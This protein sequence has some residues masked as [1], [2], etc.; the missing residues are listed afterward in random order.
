M[1]KE[2]IE[3]LSVKWIDG[4]LS[5]SEEKQLHALME[6]DPEM[7]ADLH[8]MKAVAQSL[9]A[10]LPA[11]VE[12]PYGDF[13][14]S[15]LMRKV[16]LQVAAQ[17]PAKKAVRWWQ[18]LRWAWAPV[19]ALALVLSFF[20]G[21]RI[22]RPGAEGGL[23]ETGKGAQA[24]DAMAALP[25]VYFAGEAMDADVIANADGDVSVIVV[26]G[27]SAIPDDVDFSV[28]VTTKELPKSYNS[29]EARRFQ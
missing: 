2:T 26:N 1:K 29:A 6:N 20:A 13:F 27:I 7:G 9:K 15:Q 25:T 8:E 24:V 22:S 23:A 14:N 5:P 4:E 17:R 12:P 10:E 3:E 16:D 28:T 11:S 21:H 19:G 18:S